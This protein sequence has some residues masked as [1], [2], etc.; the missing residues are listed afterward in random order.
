M[1]RTGG[2]EE[3]LELMT[4]VYVSEDGR[5]QSGYSEVKYLLKSF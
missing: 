1:A 3:G 4:P 2:L 5:S